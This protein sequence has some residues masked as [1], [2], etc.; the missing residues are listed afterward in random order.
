VRDWNAN[1]KFA[2]R[3]N[4]SLKRTSKT[5]K[6]NLISDSPK[7]NHAR[8]Q[9]VDA[10]R[11]LAASAVVLYHLPRVTRE[12]AG[13]PGAVE[14]IFA[15]GHYGVDAFFVL[16]GF[17][18]SLSVA[19]F[20]WTT[21][22]FL[23]F[24]VKRSIR[25]DPSYWAAISVEI[26]LGFVAIWFFGDEYQFPTLR[27]VVAHLFYA[28]GVLGIPEISDVFWTLCFEIQFYVAMV[29]ILVLSSTHAAQ[30]LLSTR[31]WLTVALAVLALLSVC[32]RNEW[33]PSIN[34]GLAIPRAYQFICGVVVYLIS[35]KHIKVQVGISFVLLL[36]VTRLINGAYAETVVSTITATVCFLSARGTTL[37]R[38][39]NLPP[40][41]LLGRMSYSLYLY[42]ASIVG[43]V[44][45]LAAT[46]YGPSPEPL[47]AWLSIIV[48]IAMALAFS[49]LMFRL[50]EEPSLKL[51][52]RI[53]LNQR[54][55]AK[56]APF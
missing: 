36:F 34:S 25:L 12:A 46:T 7:T 26:A 14:A 37:N 28:Q 27:S 31:T 55:G 20:Q 30:R 11:G 17:V 39:S 8:L 4:A 6:S 50:V 40:L 19:N 29:A 51:S 45:A 35:G 16:S 5:G 24:V 44:A 9:A 41:Q 48:S 32:F 21:K 47:L 53:P 23:S 54:S 56:V 15:N 52:R 22:F 3:L 2:H 10:L 38:L 49:L 33:L 43:R 1:A 18:I 13:L 42:H